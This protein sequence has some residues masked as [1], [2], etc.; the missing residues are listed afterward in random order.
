MRSVTSERSPERSVTSARS[1][2]R[3]PIYPRDPPERS[4]ETSPERKRSSRGNEACKNSKQ[5]PSHNLVK[6]VIALLIVMQVLHVCIFNKSFA[7]VICTLTNSIA[8]IPFLVLSG[9]YFP[10]RGAIYGRGR[11]VANLG[12]QCHLTLDP[13]YILPSRRSVH[14]FVVSHPGS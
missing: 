3:S 10:F 14:Y 1:P 5:E 12:G 4:L 8:L 11:N 6:R 2:E 13:Y 7:L 9:Y